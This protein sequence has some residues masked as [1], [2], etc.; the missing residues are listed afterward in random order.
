M[1]TDRIGLSNLILDEPLVREHIQ[2]EAAPLPVAKGLVRWVARPAERREFYGG[3]PPAARLVRPARGLG[4]HRRRRAR[5]G[6]RPVRVMGAG[7]VQGL[8]LLLAP[9]GWRLLRATVRVVPPSPPPVSG[10][11]I[12]AC[13]HRDILPAILHVRAAR[14]VLMVSSSPDGDILVRTLGERDYGFVRGSGEEHG[15]RAFVALCRAVEEGR[16]R[17]WRWTGPRGPSAWCATG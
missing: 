14:P 9:L 10:P 6:R 11:R 15:G 12:F 3:G 4:A 7:P 8:K 2:Q 5:P 17:G 1:R 16:A 13:L